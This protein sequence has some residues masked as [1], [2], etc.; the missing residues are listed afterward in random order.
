MTLTS[1]NHDRLLKGL[2]QEYEQRFGRSKALYERA[3]CVLIDGVSHGSRLFKPYPFHVASASGAGV[4]DVDG[5]RI[6]DFWQGHYANILGHNPRIV[7]EALTHELASGLGLQTGFPQERQIEFAEILAQAVGAERVRFTTSGT[8]AI[9]YSCMLARAFT[10]RKLVLKMSGGWHGASPSVLK[11]IA[12]TESGFDKVDSAGVSSTVEQETIL[13]RFNDLDRLHDVFST[14]GERIAC[15]IFEPCMGRAG[16]VAATAEFMR[17]ARQLTERYGALLVLD[18]VITGF[19]YCASGVQRLYDVEADL[20]I[21]GKIVGGGMPL[22]A[23]TGRD[24][25][26]ALASKEA[27]NRVW[28]NGGTFSA[29]PLCLL[30]GKTLVEYLIEHESGIYPALATR[31]ERL[32]TGIEKVFA[33][34]GILA[35]C[36][37]HGNGAITG[38]SLASVYFPLRGDHHPSSAEDLLDPRLCDVT[39]REEA[40]KLGLLLE[41]VNVMHGLGA[42]SH[43]HTE[44]DL[45][46]VFDAYD[47]FALRLL[48]ER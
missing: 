17:A 41:N 21:F 10:G 38:G 7:R 43:S 39:L 6:I 37:G 5:N 22:S 2:Y 45:T 4:T 12:R 27:A 23:V 15:L 26:M 34:R 46:R 30:A 14:H 8:L 20:S 25:V 32:R 35:H 44:Q 42:L 29:H 13:T 16:F 24:E 9:M 11:G 1:D 36:T 48:A 47:S 40:L 3:L 18:E 28:F 31:G 33:D 19:R